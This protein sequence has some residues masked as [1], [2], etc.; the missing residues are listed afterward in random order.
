MRPYH[1]KR[2]KK[3]HQIVAHTKEAKMTTLGEV[4]SRVLSV[5]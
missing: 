5:S 4:G 2:E 1:K 3:E